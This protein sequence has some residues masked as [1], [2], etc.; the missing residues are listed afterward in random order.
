M[1]L[2]IFLVTA[3]L[4]GA[5]V[6]AERPNL[7]I[8]F[9]DDQGYGD[10]GCFGGK[11]VYTPHIDQMAKEG[12]RLTSFYVAAPVCTPSRAALMTGCYPQRIDMEICSSLTID[13]PNLPKGKHFP[14]C[15]AGDGKGLNPDETTIAEV[16]QSVG[17]KTGMFGKWHLGDQPVFLPTRQGFEEFFGLPYSHD[18]MPKHPGQKYFKFPPL[19]LLEGEEV[20]ELDPDTNY[21]TRR[22][23]EKAVDFIK[24][25]KEENFF[26]YLAHPLPHGPLAAS[27]EIRKSYAAVRKAGAPGRGDIYNTAKNEIDWS[28]GQVLDTLKEQGIDENTIVLFTS[29]NGPSRG[30]AKPLRGKKGK[31]L[32]GGQ[33]MPTVIRWPNGIPAGSVNDEVLTAMDI[34]PTFA[35]VSGATLDADRE[36]DGKDIMPV[37]VEG[38]KSPHQYFF[39]AYWGNL[40]AVRWGDWKFR[41]TD[42]EEALYNLAED[43]SEKKNLAAQNPEI[44]AKLRTAMKDFES[45]MAR[46][47]RPVGLVENPKPLTLTLKD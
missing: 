5:V 17:Y 24:R 16:A 23:T 27:E 12:A 2:R 29:D 7:V 22:F 36:I 35:K 15:L 26:L 46:E 4:V 43:I 34:L 28:V 42:G 8:I 11:Q 39:Y 38:A 1:I 44:V 14:V 6:A 47:V 19:P 31:T 20:V 37:L 13:K 9:T 25:N 21:L 30:S 45:E 10:L 41:I 40:E 33:R 18:I 3:L 32:E